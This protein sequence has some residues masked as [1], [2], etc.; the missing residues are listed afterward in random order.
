LTIRT[1]FPCVDHDWAIRCWKNCGAYFGRGEL[2]VGYEPFNKPNACW[3]FKN[4][5]GYKIPVNSEGINMFTNKKGEDFTI[6][7][8]EIWG[9]RFKE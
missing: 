3:S 4:H 5:S 7:S 9:V 1:S 6:S 8:I 2:S